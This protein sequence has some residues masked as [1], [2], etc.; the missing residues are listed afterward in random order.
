MSGSPKAH[1]R[2]ERAVGP[3]I[4]QRVEKSAIRIVAG[5]QEEL[6]ELGR[7]SGRGAALEHGDALLADRLN[8]PAK[9]LNARA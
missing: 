8:Y 3:A 9:L 2:R 4:D 1:K 6:P 7:R 5:R